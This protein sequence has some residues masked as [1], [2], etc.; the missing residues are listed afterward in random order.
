[1]TDYSGRYR[2]S[3]FRHSRRSNWAGI[4]RAGLLFGLL[5]SVGVPLALNG[6][7][8]SISNVTS[9]PID[10]LFTLTRMTLAYLL[11]IGFA[12]VYG[13]TTGM[14]HRASHVTL[15]LLD[16]LQSVPVLGFLPPV[17]IFFITRFPGHLGAEIS[18]IILIFTAMVWA[19][20]FG[21]I[22]GVNAI[23]L[24]IKEASRAYGIKGWSYLR[25]I[26]LPAVYP[27]LVW[28]SLLAWG[29]GW[30]LIPVEENFAFNGVSHALPGLGFYIANAAANLDLDSSLFGLAVLVL[31][32]LAIDEVIWKP[33]G[34]RAEKYKYETVAAPQTGGA[35]HS[36]VSANVRKYEQRLVSP[37]VSL[38]KYERTSI[39][40]FL[41]AVHLRR[42]L[43]VPERVHLQDRF[44]KHARL[45]RIVAFLIAVTLI[46]VSIPTLRGIQLSSLG[47]ALGTI[48][49]MVGY[50]NL[51]FD[52]G[53]S[54]LRILIAYLIALSWTLGAGILIARNERA[55]K[56]LIPVF[57][58][59]Q[60]IPGTA[61]FPIIILLVV[62]PLGG[63]PLGLNL[64]SILLL[65]TGMQWYLLFNIVGA[66]RGLST[67]LLE[68]SSA[69]GLK[70]TRFVKEILLPASF[71]AIL[72]GSIQAWGGGWNATIVSEYINESHKVPG[73]GSLLQTATNYNDLYASAVVIT[74]AVLIMTIS[75]L[76]IN[77]I[78]WRRLLR[79]AEK[80]K[81]ET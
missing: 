68:A 15:P 21:V 23:P 30:Y 64:A 7:S 53:S 60:S 6:F 78:V 9:I 72:I 66:V 62:N 59:L 8:I 57:D 47:G 28:S 36:G 37:L 41:E 49:A 4:P 75:V 3:L 13:I 14:S 61:L 12:L 19:P 48:D 71:P 10:A 55:S 5:G 29:G 38:F 1:M 39:T 2:Q 67:D 35:R 70:G 22:A 56:M 69:Y 77:R 17:F 51:V 45:G 25:Q 63:S 18:S 24:D 31:I 11:S 44:A 42:R 54:L 34:S 58:V 46:L 27:E 43:H 81:M 20:T 33:L 40:S 76:T 73:L 26:V 16:V 79:K 74:A 50:A 32:I 65:L 52:T 80:Y